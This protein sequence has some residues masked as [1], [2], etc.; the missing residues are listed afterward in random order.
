VD[1]LSILKGLNEPKEGFVW[2]FDYFRD[3]LKLL[4]WGLWLFLIKFI[5][6]D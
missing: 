1:A 5:R 4:V 6:C 2:K 3:E